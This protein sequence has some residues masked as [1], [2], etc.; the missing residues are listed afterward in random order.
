MALKT[1]DEY[2]ERLKN[3]KPNVYAHGKQI[4]RDDPMLEKPINVLR[5]TFGLAQD[6]AYKDLMLTKSHLT[7][8]LINRFTSLNLSWA[9]HLRQ[10]P[11]V[12]A[13]RG[14]IN[15][16]T[17][18]FTCVL[19]RRIRKGSLFGEQR[20]ILPWDLMLMSISS[21]PRGPLQQKKAIGLSLLPS[22]QMQMASS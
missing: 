14:P 19:S 1:S 22:R 12:T 4:R 15:K 20:I 8:E 13:R 2:V 18:T 11:K 10:M 6:P 16:K 9:V 7:G 5:L 21:F 17:L 3:M